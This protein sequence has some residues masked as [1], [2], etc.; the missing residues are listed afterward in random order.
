MNDNIAMNLGARCA[1]RSAA[2]AEEGLRDIWMSGNTCRMLGASPHAVPE[3]RGRE[4]DASKMHRTSRDVGVEGRVN[5]RRR[6][7]AQPKPTLTLLRSTSPLDKYRSDIGCRGTAS[8]T[9]D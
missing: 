9:R 5:R 1:V 7:R 8:L 2:E 3:E 4:R 6:R